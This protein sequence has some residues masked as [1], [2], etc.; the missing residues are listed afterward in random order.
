M[1]FIAEGQ[2]RRVLCQDCRAVSEV[3]GQLLMISIVVIAFS[4]IAVTVFSDHGAVKPEHIPHTDL[5]ENFNISDNKIQIVHSGGEAIDKSAIKII[6]NVDGEKAGEFEGAHN[7]FKIYRPD[8]IED[9]VFT[10]GNYI[11]IKNSSFEAGKDIDIYFIDTPSQQ[12]IQKAVLQRDSW[13][14]PEWITPHPYGSVYDD[15]DGWQ[16]TELVADYND[17][18][19][20]DSS[21][22]QKTWVTENYT[23]G[24]DADEMGIPNTLSIVQLMIIYKS[25]DS[26]STQVLSIFDGSKWIQIAPSEYYTAPPY[27]KTTEDCKKAN[28]IYDITNFVKTADELEKLEVSFSDNGNAANI[29]GKTDWVDYVGIHVK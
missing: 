13:E 24:I 10:L 20:T 6:V 17:G 28:I 2:K 14:I 8:G 3:Y 11:E 9:T 22:P 18:L 7:D 4:T 1:I 16:P 15:S 25:H 21:I 27:F 29:S 19:L 23:F 26:S 5:Q 12:V